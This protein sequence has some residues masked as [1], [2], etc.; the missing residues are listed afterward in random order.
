MTANT[1]VVLTVNGA[2]RDTRLEHAQKG[3]EGVSTPQI[4]GKYAPAKK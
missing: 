2:E 3:G 1:P 4:G